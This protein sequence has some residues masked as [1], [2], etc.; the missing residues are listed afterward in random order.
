MGEASL[1]LIGLIATFP[2]AIQ[3]AVVFFIL[4]GGLLFLGK[5]FMSV[6]H[7]AKGTKKK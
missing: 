4:I 2:M 3:V 6:L 1:A 7:S 5:S